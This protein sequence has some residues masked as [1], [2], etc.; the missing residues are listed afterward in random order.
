M[1]KNRDKRLTKAK[2]RYNSEEGREKIKASQKR[3][4]EKQKANLGMSPAT[5][6]QI[7]NPAQKL[8]KNLNKRISRALTMQ[9]VEKSGFTEDL[10]GINHKELATYFES[11]WEDDMSW[12]NYGEWHIDHIRPCNSFDLL[13]RSQ[14]LVCFNWRNLQP[15]WAAENHSKYDDYTPLD[16]LAWVERMQALGYEGELFLKY[17]EGNSF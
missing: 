16:E 9:G 13:D 4:Y 7:E 17:E 1:T 15:M 11:I 5:K 2:E 10:C 14:Q 12:D 8:K 6:Y 3:W